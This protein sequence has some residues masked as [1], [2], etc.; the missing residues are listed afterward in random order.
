MGENIVISMQ[1]ITK[2][3][4]SLTAV[5]RISLDL[6][7][8]EF[9]ALLGPS[10]CGKTTLLRIMAGFEDLDE[11]KLLLDGKDMA[12]HS[13][14]QRPINLMFQ[15][16]ALFPHMSARANISYGLE[17]ERLPS[18]QIK[19]RVDEILEMTQLSELAARMPN[20]LSGGQRQR[21]AL[22]RALIKKPRV[23]LLDEPLGALDKKLR[24]QM[25]LELKRLQHE[26]GITFVVVTHDQEEALVMAD[27]IA[28]IKD[29]RIAQLDEPKALYERPVNRFVAQFVGVTNLLEGTAIDGGI[30]IA[31]LGEVRADSAADLG[32]S[33]A[34]SVRPERIELSKAGKLAGCN[35]APGRITDMAY[36]GQGM[37]LFVSVADLEKPL[38]VRISAA[39]E[40]VENYSIGQQIWCNWRPGDGR[41]LTD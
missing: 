16:Y 33:C 2:R 6:I 28:L 17:M 26:L 4:G 10:G 35:A 23:L 30:E 22:A 39:D 13:A 21:V 25:Q 3:F 36:H 29:G 18:S 27:R 32:T 14:N 7:E 11:G 34:L 20:Q 37:N 19:N 5:N 9:F 1:Q 40:A 15:S 24:E 12:S 8:G 38:A 31:G 41:I